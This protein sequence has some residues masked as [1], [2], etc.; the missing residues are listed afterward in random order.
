MKKQIHEIVTGIS[1]LKKEKAEHFHVKQLEITKKSLEAKLRKLINSPKRDDVVS[2]EEL[3]ID[4]L[5][6]DEAHLFK[7][8]YLNTKMRNISGISTNDNVQKT[9]DL[10]MKCQYLDEITGGKGIVFATGTPVITGYQGSKTPILRCF[11]MICNYSL[12]IQIGCCSFTLQKPIYSL[13]Q[14][15]KTYPYIFSTLPL[16]KVSDALIHLNR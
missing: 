2:F 6:V 11:I 1:E 5:I 12:K 16:P 7:N 9:A 10:Y 14:I 8:L 13:S 4:K 15:I 3:G